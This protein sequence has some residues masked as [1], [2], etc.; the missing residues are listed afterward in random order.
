V[1]AKADV[2]QLVKARLSDE[3]FG[4]WLMVVDNA[5]DDSVLFDQLQE[6]GGT[7]R[8]IDHLPRSRKGSIVFTTRIRKAA[9]KLAGSNHIQLNELNEAEAKKM[10]EQKMPNED[11]LEDG[12]V[13]HEFLELLTY[14]P[15][16]IVQ[17]V[18]FIVG[19]N[20]R[21]SEYMDLYKAS[22]SDATDLLK[23][24][25]EDQGRYRQIQ[26]P[27][28]ITW[29]ISF[30]KIQE[31]D[32]LAAEYLSL[33]ACTTGEAV[34]ASLL[35]PGSTKLATIEALG[36]LSAYTFITERQQQQSNT[37][38]PHR[39]KAYNMHRLVRLATR[40]WLRENGQ[41][42]EWASK[43][44]TRLVEIVPF[45]DRDTREMWTTYLPHA[46]HVVGMPELSEAEER[47][48][49]LERVGY[50]E[51]TLGRYRAAELAHREELGRRGKIP[52]NRHPDTLR[53]MSNLALALFEQGKYAE[54]EAIY[55]TTLPLQENL[56]G[57]EHPDTLLSISNLAVVLSGQ[58][59]YVEAATMH[60]ESLVVR[61]KVLGKEHPHTL[62]SMNN[63]A[64]ALSEQ[65]KYAEAEAIYQETLA[66]QK[67]VLGKEHP[68]T[69]KS[70]NNLALAL[71]GQRKYTEAEAIQ[72]ETLTL[73]EKVLGKE[74]P[75]TLLSI[76]NL[77][78]A[79]SKQGKYAEAEAM[80]QK[81]LALI[82]KVLGKEHPNTLISMNILGEALSGQRKY[83]EAEAIHSK[84]LVL[85]EKVLGKE[86]AD[87]LECMND[88]ALA[89]SGQGNYAEAEAMN[90]ETLVVR[91][92]VLGK[93]HPDTLTS[94]NNLALA[95]SDQGKYAEAESMHQETL[96]LR[97][98][99]LGKEHPDT[100]ASIYCLAQSLQLQDQ[101]QEA[102]R[103]YERACTGYQN[104]LGPDHPVTRACFG[105]YASAQRS[106]DAFLSAKKRHELTDT[107]LE[108]VHPASPGSSTAELT[109]RPAVGSG[110]K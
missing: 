101:Y 74:H 93:E 32:T 109:L 40:N 39:E 56:L 49:L 34:P 58:G 110:G 82:E 79:L 86:H 13:V 5:D 94:M 31:Q 91:E 72:Q 7:D 68:D 52:G 97:E 10:L 27:V 89:L 33:M 51:R 75:H 65:G 45:G 64:L 81:T 11:L 66:L 99:V 55:Q 62:L 24:D 102:L 48:W 28:A 77:A 20:I 15:L 95:L 21:L 35:W 46:M 92:K 90:Q 3:G 98:K 38:A 71:G 1:D 100:L 18:A 60:Q 57:K 2:K 104:T 9:V 78:L 108:N 105:N 80:H 19:N 107:V 76:D 84:A 54:A 23:R 87:T 106:A 63:V 41:W 25:F 103:L 53:S 26:N 36:T 67:K 8:L 4:Q 83:A 96:A 17:A 37:G 14:L 6:G 59:K 50:C 70:M 43:A 69:L 42:Q 73:R 85:Q 88:L 22:E 47:V 12:K 61:E 16:A 44:L 29:Y 30:S